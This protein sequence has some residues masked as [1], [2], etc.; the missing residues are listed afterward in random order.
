[1]YQITLISPNRRKRSFFPLS[2]IAQ[3]EKEWAKKKQKIPNDKIDT[4]RDEHMIYFRNRQTDVE[5][6]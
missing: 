1:M 6:I 3:S 5:K 4:K 2:W